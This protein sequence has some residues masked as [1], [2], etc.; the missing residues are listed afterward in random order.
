MHLLKKNQLHMKNNQSINVNILKLVVFPFVIFTMAFLS[1]CNDD[2]PERE[3]T[4]EMI[5]KATLTF[6]PDA[7]TPVVVTATDPD[8]EGVQDISVD[9]P[10]NLEAN[11]SYTLSISLINELAQPSDPAYNIT[12]EVEEEGDEHMLFF[13]WTNNL[14]T[15]PAGNGNVDNR[16][17]DVNYEDQDANSQ[18]L[19]L[20]TLWIAGGASSGTFRVVLKH[21]PGLKT[22]TSGSST[23]ETD[24]DITFAINII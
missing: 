24:L 22:G 23:G 9:G 8:G 5:T 12:Q 1:G 21:Q 15:D 16:N 11:K 3:D 2:D 14:F 19:G 18:P 6:T 13:E 7:G 17:D 20:E 4:P 10:I